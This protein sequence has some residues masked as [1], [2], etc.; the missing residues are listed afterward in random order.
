MQSIPVIVKSS[1]QF[2]DTIG[3]ISNNNIVFTDIDNNEFNDHVVVE[4]IGTIEHV[5]VYNPENNPKLWSDK[6]KKNKK[7]HN[8]TMK[9]CIDKHI[10]NKK[11]E[12]YDIKFYCE[13]NGENKE[14]KKLA[15][16]LHPMFDNKDFMEYSYTSDGMPVNKK[17]STVVKHLLTPVDELYDVSGNITCYEYHKSL[18]KTLND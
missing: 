10:V 6:F 5:Y 13:Y 1:E 3:C 8:C 12:S 18:L 2:I 15:R 16:K 14:E 4:P 17:N 11:H 9:I 7:N